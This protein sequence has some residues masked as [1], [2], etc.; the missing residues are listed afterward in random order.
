MAL[1][2]PATTMISDAEDV[3]LI[4]SYDGSCLSASTTR[5]L[6][7]NGVFSSISKWNVLP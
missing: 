7:D 4:V 2:T 3:T 1:L 6:G 5:Y